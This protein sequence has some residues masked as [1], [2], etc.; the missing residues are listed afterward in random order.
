MIGDNDELRV[1]A[2]MVKVFD[3]Y[4]HQKQ[5]KKYFRPNAVKFSAMVFKSGNLYGDNEYGQQE[6]KC[7]DKNDA[8]INRINSSQEFHIKKN[9]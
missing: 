7:H 5:A 9:S 3:F 6:Q 1:G 2:K 4:P 8:A